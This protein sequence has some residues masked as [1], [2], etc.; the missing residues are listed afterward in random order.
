MRLKRR[1]GGG[2]CEGYRR[3]TRGAGQGPP[4]F[5]IVENEE[6]FENLMALGGT[7]LCVL[8]LLPGSMALLILTAGLI[9]LS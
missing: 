1:G 6:A 4:Y 8:R 3:G 7:H 5:E 9:C 2:W